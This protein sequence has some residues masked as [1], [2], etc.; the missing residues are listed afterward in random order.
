MVLLDER[1]GYIIPRDG[2]LKSSGDCLIKST[3]KKKPKGFSTKG[4]SPS[5]VAFISKNDLEDPEK[6]NRNMRNGMRK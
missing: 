5:L 1:D 2:T 3:E 6:G 4:I